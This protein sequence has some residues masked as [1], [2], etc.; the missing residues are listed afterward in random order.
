MIAGNTGRVINESVCYGQLTEGYEVMEKMVLRMQWAADCEL[1]PFLPSIG[2]FGML[3]I[4]YITNGM[5][6]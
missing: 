1:R 2:F 6:N 3:L 4:Q 5:A